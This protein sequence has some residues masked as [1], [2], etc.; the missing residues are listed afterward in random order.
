MSHSVAQKQ[1]VFLDRDGTINVDP[2]YLSDPAQVELIKGAGEALALLHKKGFE[3]VVVSNQ[4]GVGRGIIQESALP[5][6][7]QRLN[8]LLRPYQV[9]I[10]HFEL[11][12]HAPEKDC[13]CRKPKPELLLR[14]VSRLGL[15]VS[16]C[17]MVGDRLTD[18]QAG[19]AA[20]CEKVAL[21]RTG[22]GRETETTLNKKDADFVGDSLKE[23]ARWIVDQENEG[24]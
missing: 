7:H 22:Y 6:I 9:K 12:I 11:C 8:E 19:R 15:N 3:L 21:V 10:E 23:V 5:L 2:G 18:L 4:S 14:A 17:Y 20:R 16:R 1:A 13:A 24:S